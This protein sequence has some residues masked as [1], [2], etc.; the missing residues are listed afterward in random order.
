LRLA[1][2]VRHLG[3]AY[4]YAGQLS[5]AEPCYVEALSIYRT[6][7]HKP[8]LDLANAIRSFAVLKAELGAADEARHLWEEAHDLYVA[9]EVSA[10]VAE[11]AARLAL[12]A[13]HEGDIERSRKWFDKAL[14][15]AG[16]TDDR[17]TQEYIREVK[18]QIDNHVEISPME[19]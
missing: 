12:L 2:K 5:L 4:Y 18:A 11:S 6:Q 1:H 14:V 19:V 9:V 7:E 8:P 13:R 10:G 15:A 17:E 16:D 3:D